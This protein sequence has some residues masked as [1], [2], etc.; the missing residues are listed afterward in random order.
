[1]YFVAMLE[2]STIAA[3]LGAL[4]FIGRI[5]Y[6]QGYATGNPDK[7]ISSGGF[8]FVIAQLGTIL[9]AMKVAVH[10]SLPLLSGLLSSLPRFAGGAAK[11]AATAEP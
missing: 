10:L 1:M 3:V 5:L 2:H 4:F 8:L 6:F 7:R 11:T 9:V